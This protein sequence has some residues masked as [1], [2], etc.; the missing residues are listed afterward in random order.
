MP[1]ECQDGSE[2]I[3]SSP[4]TRL[5]NIC[6]CLADDINTVAEML[7]GGVKG[8]ILVP[9]VAFPLAHITSWTF[10]HLVWGRLPFKEHFIH[11][12]H[13]SFSVKYSELHLKHTPP[14]LPCSPY[15]CF[16]GNSNYYQILVRVKSTASAEETIRRSGSFRQIIK[17]HCYCTVIYDRKRC[18]CH[19]GTR[20]WSCARIHWVMTAVSPTAVGGCMVAAAVCE[21]IEEETHITQISLAV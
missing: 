9:A 10:H 7:D 12:K 5:Q 20:F 1:P 21:G 2:A 15:F 3:S 8:N 17:L 13:C 18:Q 14:P 16:M 11:I 19:A 6:L 4:R